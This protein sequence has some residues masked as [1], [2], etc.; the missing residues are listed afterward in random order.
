MFTQNRGSLLY[1]AVDLVSNTE[2]K[3]SKMKL[4]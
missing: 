2:F 3:S 4:C 1:M